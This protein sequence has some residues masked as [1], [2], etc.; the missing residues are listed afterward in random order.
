MN[1]D[2]QLRIRLTAEDFKA[3]VAGKQIEPNSWCTYQRCRVPVRLILAD[4]GFTAMMEAI[5][6]AIHGKEPAEPCIIPP[7]EPLRL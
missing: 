7:G 2:C 1:D 5:E 3:L 4:I 6:A